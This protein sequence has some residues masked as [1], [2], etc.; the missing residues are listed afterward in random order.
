MLR[1]ITSALL[2]WA[3]LVGW[4]I[5]ITR[6]RDH[7]IA[8]GFAGGWMWTAIATLLQDLGRRRCRIGRPEDI[9]QA[10]LSIM[11]NGYMTGSVVHVDGG[12]RLV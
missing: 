1:R 7:A 10:V 12:Q 6:D 5:W 11:T 9:A 8:F 3:V 4:A 2:F